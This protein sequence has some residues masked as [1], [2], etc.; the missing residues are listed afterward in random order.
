MS[1]TF[2][3]YCNRVFEDSL[4]T[5]SCGRKTAPMTDAHREPGVILLS[6]IAA[7]KVWD[8]E[9]VYTEEDFREDWDREMESLEDCFPPKE[10]S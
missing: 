7:A 6:G 3:G 2:C 9:V 10:T 5:C 1:G 8:E 4:S